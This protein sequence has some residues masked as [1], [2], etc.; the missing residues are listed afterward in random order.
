MAENKVKQET[1]NIPAELLDG[2]KLNDFLAF[3]DF[4]KSSKLSKSTTNKAKTSW[5]IK[6]KGKLICYLRIGKNTWS[7]SYFKNRELL[8]QIEIYLSDELKKIILN[9]INTK[10]GCPNCKGNENR[11]VLGKKFDRVCGCHLFV[12]RNPEEQIFECAKE[13]ILVCKKAIDEL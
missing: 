4:I 8:E 1:G 13:L 5:A 11:V 10:P 7:I 2:V 9:N 6:Y 3:N 12:L